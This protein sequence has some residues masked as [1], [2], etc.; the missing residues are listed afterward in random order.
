[1]AASS[2]GAQMGIIAS[3]VSVAV[4]SLV[5]ML[6]GITINGKSLE[7]LDLLAITIP[8]TLIGILAIGIFSWFRGKDLDKDPEFQKFISV[9]ENYEYVYGDSATLL[10]KVTENQ[11]GCY[12]DFPRFYWGCCDF[13]GGF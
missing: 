12:V 9:H 2:I 11:L 7:F 3:P 6:N 4:V 1:M 8:S 5:A 13:G 10:D